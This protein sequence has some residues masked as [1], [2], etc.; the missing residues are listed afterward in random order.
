[1]HLGPTTLADSGS[2]SISHRLSSIP[3]QCPEQARKEMYMELCQPGVVSSSLQKTNDCA[4]LG[5]AGGGRETG[6]GHQSCTEVLSG[7]QIIARLL[8]SGYSQHFTRAL[9]RKAAH[10]WPALTV[11]SVHH[12]HLDLHLCIMPHAF[13]LPMLT[14]RCLLLL[15]VKICQERRKVILYL[16]HSKHF[17]RSCDSTI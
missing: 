13:P 6:T 3:G 16:M 7:S 10:F 15:Y 17:H 14:E 9:Q 12:S 1:M 5:F 11:L 2:H 8:R 4:E